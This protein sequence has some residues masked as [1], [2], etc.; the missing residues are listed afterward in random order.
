MLQEL[1]NDNLQDIITEKNK[2]VVQYGASWC[3]SCRIMKPKMKRL[4]K[5]YDAV[6][7]LYVDAEKLPES[8]KLAAVT[9]LPTFATFKDG[10]LVNQTQ[11]NKEENLKALIDEIA[12]N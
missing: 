11:T 7:F 4:A 9:N 10:V 8:R 5:D 12:N 6:T 2:V 3:G 1:E